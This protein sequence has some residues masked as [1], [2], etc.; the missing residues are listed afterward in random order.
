MSRV[1][2]ARERKALDKLSFEHQDFLIKG[3]FAAG[4][5]VTTLDGLVKTPAVYSSMRH[6]VVLS[7]GVR[8]GEHDGHNDTGRW[9]GAARPTRWR[10]RASASAAPAHVGRAQ[11]ERRATAATRGG[12]GVGVAGA[13][14]DSGRA[15]R[16]ARCVPDRRRGVVEDPTGRWS[17]RGD[18]PPEGQGR[19]SDHGQRAAGD[20]DR[21]PGGA[22]PLARRRSR[23]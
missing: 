11:A 19:G 13:W 1:L 9:S 2:N 3:Q 10:R 6:R 8:G 18:R 21:A 17:R 22:R 20:Q 5:G 15:D 12:P 14:R 4:I 7:G 16:L 23:R